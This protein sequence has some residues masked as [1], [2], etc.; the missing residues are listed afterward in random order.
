[1]ETNDEQLEQLH[2]R[3]AALQAQQRLATELGWR[4]EGMP[5]TGLE[6]QEGDRGWDDMRDDDGEHNADQQLAQLERQLEQMSR[7]TEQTRHYEHG[8]GF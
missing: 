1:M 6:R 4:S 2:A 8:M 3:M 7:E 5:A